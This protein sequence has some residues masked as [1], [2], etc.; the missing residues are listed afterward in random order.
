MVFIHVA[1]VFDTVCHK[2]LFDRLKNVGVRGN[3]LRLF[4][5]YLTDKKQ[6]VKIDE[7]V[8]SSQSISTGVPQGTVLGPVLLL[9]YINEI[10]NMPKYGTV[11]SYADDTIILFTGVNWAELYEKAEVD[12]QSIQS[13]LDFFMTL[14]TSVANHT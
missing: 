10:E 6:R 9:I 13:W 12:L 3:T 2:K 4:E 5:N 14:S 7:T 1:K 8:S 11:I